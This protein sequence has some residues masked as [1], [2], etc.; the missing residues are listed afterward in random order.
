[1]HGLRLFLIMWVA[2]MVESLTAAPAAAW[3]TTVLDRP[4]LQNWQHPKH[5][6]SSCM[7]LDAAGNVH[8]LHIDETEAGVDVLRYVS[9]ASGTWTAEDLDTSTVEFRSP[10][11]A[12]DATGRL[13]V[14]YGFKGDSNLDTLI[15]ATNQSGVW[16]T[17]SVYTDN[18]EYDIQTQHAAIALDPSG[19][20]HIAFTVSFLG[21][22]NIVNYTTNT[23]P[24]WPITNIDTKP[25]YIGCDVAMDA[26][27]RAHMVYWRKSGDAL[28][29]A[30]NVSGGWNIETID[31][32]CDA[33]SA[34]VVIDS[35]RYLHVVYADWHKGIKYLSNASGSPVIEVVDPYDTWWTSGAWV[36]LALDGAGKARIAYT[37][38]SEQ[39]STK[40]R[41]A[42]NIGGS[43][44]TEPVDPD[45]SKNYQGI[46]IA[47]GSFSAIA[48]DAASDVHMAYR[49]SYGNEG[50]T[51]LD[52]RLKY[53]TNKSPS[54]DISGEWAFSTTNNWHGGVFG[55]TGEV[56]ETGSGTIVQTGGA[57]T[58]VF[59]GTSFSGIAGGSTYELY[60]T[61]QDAGGTLRMLSYLPGA[62]VNGSTGEI[63]WFF[64]EQNG[65][66][67]CNGG[68]QVTY[69]I[70]GQSLNPGGENGGS[71]SGGGGGGCFI[72]ALIK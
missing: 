39:G 28:V 5:G 22:D 53:A 29:Y 1:M 57:I 50:H 63:L 14:I 18:G 21:S 10:D 55:C 49:C 8:M 60:T 37:D 20:V 36:S 13:H 64:E 25:T 72:S 34:S 45:P 35:S 27:G 7:A 59:G 62:D 16:Q 9:N 58:A 68:S 23:V 66:R 52:H 56:D 33:V 11:I 15:Y 24:S 43:W 12:S 19:G 6:F 41:Y 26:L 71:S 3:V 17:T 32:Q 47:A 46:G 51:P 2:V 31:T 65:V 67:H 4:T 40:L 61:F 44:I 38:V 30:N 70:P 69:S 42:D 48:V 54:L